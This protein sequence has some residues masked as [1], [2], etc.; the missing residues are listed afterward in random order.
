MFGPV[1]AGVGA[2]LLL[3]EQVFDSL[4]ERIDGMVR[5]HYTITG[6][7]ERP[8]VKALKNAKAPAG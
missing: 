8:I 4:P 3:A 6:P 2:A 1:G 5:R 7:W